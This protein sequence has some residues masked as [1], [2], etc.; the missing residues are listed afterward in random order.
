MIRADFAARGIESELDEL[1]QYDHLI[2]DTDNY[3]KAIES[4]FNCSVRKGI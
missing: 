2:T 3:A 4:A 1:K